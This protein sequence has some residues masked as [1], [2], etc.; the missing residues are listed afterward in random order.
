MP[1]KIVFM[2]T[3]EFSVAAL[4]SLLENNYNIIK[5]YTQPPKKSKRGQKLNPTAIEK[6]CKENKLN[7]G[8]PKNLNSEEE[9][10]NFKKLSPDVVIVVAYGQIIP[11]NFLSICKFGFINIHASLLPK[12]RGAAPIQRA[13]MNGDKKL[14]VSI[15]KI[16]EKLDTGPILISKELEIDQNTTHGEIEKNLS[17]MG[18]NLLIE[19]LKIMEIGK[20]KFTDQDHTKATYA[21]KIEKNET[22]INWK[23]DANKILAHIH[24]LSPN[25]GA[26][27]E[28]KKERFKVLR[29][30]VI[31]KNG[32]PGLV[33]DE[34]LTVG[35]DS[36][37]IQILELQRQ[38]KNKQTNKE[39]LLGNKIHK[40]TILA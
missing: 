16:E 24:A 29:A 1:F 21:K 36:N 5:V 34:N 7:F 6:F 27:F 14:G 22:K 28:Y 23:L 12:W 32:Q 26:W 10:K 30:K 31:L 19:S 37:S 38:G 18:A 20:H 25:P 4:D 3:P 9:L 2:G 35:C 33:L 13:I 39:F 11:K 8:N 40:G 17:K 15:M